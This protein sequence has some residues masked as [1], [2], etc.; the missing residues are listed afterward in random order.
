MPFSDDGMSK[1]VVLIIRDGWGINPGG[2]EKAEFNS[3]ATLLAHTP[4]H[5]H[6]TDRR[7]RVDLL[8]W[9][10]TRSRE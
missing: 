4:F 2:R 9:R 6:L 7:G 10:H 1:P 3:D 8:A 5:E